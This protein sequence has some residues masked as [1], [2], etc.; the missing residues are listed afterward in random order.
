MRST[1]YSPVTAASSTLARSSRAKP[2]ISMNDLTERS[3]AAFYGQEPSSSSRRSQRQDNDELP[4]ER[5]SGDDRRSQNRRE[6][7]Q[8]VWLDTRS[9][10]DRRRQHRRASDSIHVVSLKI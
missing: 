8:N 3:V 10:Q 9:G 6:D 4:G 1:R 2:V 7:R 5:R